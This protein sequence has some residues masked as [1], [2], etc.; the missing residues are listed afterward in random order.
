MAVT[1]GWDPARRL[2]AEP[3]VAALLRAHW[4]E[5]AVHKDQMRL[6]PDFD[7]IV[8]LDEAGLFRIW[9]ARDEGQL[10]G[11]LAFFVQPHLH[12]R[13]TLT[14]VEDLFLL[15]KPY[16]RGLTGYR[17]FTTAIDA[18]RELGVKRVICHSKV[19][20]ETERGGLDKFF[21][22]LGFIHTDNFW[23]RML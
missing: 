16:R 20:F 18:L 2:F 11:Y 21:Q 23:S 15:A 22:R 14:A 7:R 1:F 19:H 17:M 12:Y 6:D 4:D 9:A 10:V 13:S 8:Q 5:L 3:N